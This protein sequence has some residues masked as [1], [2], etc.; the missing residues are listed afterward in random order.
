MVAGIYARIF[1]GRP[2]R[3]VGGAPPGDRRQGLCERKGWVVGEVFVDDDVS[4]WRGKKRPAYE[5]MLK[6]L[7]AGEITAVAVYDL[8]RLHRRPRNLGWFFDFATVT[9]PRIWPASP[10]MLTWGPAT[11]SVGEDH[12]LSSRQVLGRHLP[13]DQAQARGPGGRGTPRRTPTIRVQPRRLQHRP[14]RG[15]AAP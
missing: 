5:A 15:R 2:G 14:C 8:D 13:A 9:G 6:A 4:A 3:R 12:R 1:E 11:A 7:A 10:G